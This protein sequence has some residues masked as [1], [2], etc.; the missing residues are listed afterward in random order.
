MLLTA[1]ERC[2]RLG[3][4]QGKCQRSVWIE[5]SSL[6]HCTRPSLIPDREGVRRLRKLKFWVA[7][8]VFIRV[9]HHRLRVSGYNAI[10]RTNRICVAIVTESRDRQ[11]LGGNIKVREVPAEGNWLVRSNLEVGC[12]CLCWL[13]DRQPTSGC[14]LG[15]AVK[16]LISQTLATA[17]SPWRLT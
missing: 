15:D 9:P 7:L 8:I 16:I 12:R 6:P 10:C 1:C 4:V 5:H 13:S 17:F 3:G 2:I 14:C 11:V